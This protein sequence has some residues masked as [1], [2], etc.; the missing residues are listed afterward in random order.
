MEVKCLVHTLGTEA[1]VVLKQ[2]ARWALDSVWRSGDEKNHQLL[3]G[4]KMHFLDH[5]VC[6]LVIISVKFRTMFK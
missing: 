1:M 6:S 3:A 5:P 2:E 4:I